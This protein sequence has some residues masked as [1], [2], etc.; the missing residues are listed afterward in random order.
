MF[1]IFSSKHVCYWFHLFDFLVLTVVCFFFF[2]QILHRNCKTLVRHMRHMHDVIDFCL[3]FFGVV[4]VE[5]PTSSWALFS[6]S[7]LY[8]LMSRSITR[9]FS[10]TYRIYCFFLF[11]LFVVV[12]VCLLLVQH[13]SSSFLKKS[14]RGNIFAEL[15][16]WK[17]FALCSYLM[18]N[19]GGL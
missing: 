6:T 1:N 17:C 3:L 7:K 14:L 2:Y 11:Y 4:V 19:I 12:L 15:R 10:T 8:W 13:N 18:D 9:I 16:L 5:R